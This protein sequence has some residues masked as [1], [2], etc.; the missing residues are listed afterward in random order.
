VISQVT[1]LCSEVEHAVVV[2]EDEALRID[3]S[4]FSHHQLRL[5]RYLHM[6]TY[7]Q[8]IQKA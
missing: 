6:P 1:E 3:Q 5:R 7:D 4:I 8:S 2:V